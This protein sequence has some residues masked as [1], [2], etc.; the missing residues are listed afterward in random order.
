MKRVFSFLAVVIIGLILIS[1]VGILI[2]LYKKPESYALMEH[3]SFIHFFL[4]YDQGV[5]FSVLK[6]FFSF[7]LLLSWLWIFIRPVKIIKLSYITYV[8]SFLW[9]F[10]GILVL[11]GVNALLQ[12]SAGAPIK[13][14]DLYALIISIKLETLMVL[15]IGVIV[16]PLSLMLIPRLH[17]RYV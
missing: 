4:L 2:K 10:M 7:S 15:V 16:L 14:W 11:T 5:E 3:I 9:V 6:L 17:N 8:Y 12:Y 13:L 1:D